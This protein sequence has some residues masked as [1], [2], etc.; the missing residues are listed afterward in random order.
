ML[1]RNFW[2]VT[3]NGV[4]LFKGLTQS[5]AYAKA[6]RWQGKRFTSGLLKHKDYGDHVEVKRDKEAEREWND[7]YKVYKAGDR[8]RLIFVERR[9]D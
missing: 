4:P 6:E 7:R 1:D 3:V 5:Q 9:E 2:M 8:Q